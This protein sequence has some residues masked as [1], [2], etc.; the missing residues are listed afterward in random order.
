MADIEKNIEA[1]LSSLN[2]LQPAKATP[3]FYTR[4]KARLDTQ[5]RGHLARPALHYWSGAVIVALVCI[6][7]YSYFNLFQPLADADP[8][9]QQSLALFASE[10]RWQTATIYGQAEILP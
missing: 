2:D 7:L 3:Y 10:Y 8:D 5:E 9:R 6:S 1:A 4:L